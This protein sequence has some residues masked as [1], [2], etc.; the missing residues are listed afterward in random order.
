MF[1]SVIKGQI[2]LFKPLYFNILVQKYKWG[3]EMF[4]SSAVCNGISIPG[5]DKVQ[6]GF[7]EEMLL[8]KQD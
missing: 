1:C 6:R 4:S 7:L 5:H 8:F 2:L 3:R